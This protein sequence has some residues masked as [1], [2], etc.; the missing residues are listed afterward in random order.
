[1]AGNQASVKIFH[2]V[3]E[4]IEKPQSQSNATNQRYQRK[5]RTHC[6][7]CKERGHHAVVCPQRVYRTDES[8]ERRRRKKGKMFQLW[9]TRPLRK[10]LQTEKKK[11][12]HKITQGRRLH[13]KLCS[14]TKRS[15]ILLPRS[16]IRRRS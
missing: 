15:R 13:P 6:Y 14:N 7:V 8:S 10:F 1:M 9:S 11:Q 2:F 3:V 4:V 5:D 12:D 16:S